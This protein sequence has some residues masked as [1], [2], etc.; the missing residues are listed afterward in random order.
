MNL[1]EHR[2]KS[3]KEME[4]SYLTSQSIKEFRPGPLLNNAPTVSLPM[5]VYAILL[6]LAAVVLVLAC[7]NYTNLSVARAITRAKEIG[8]RKVTGAKRKDLI[9][10]FL[11]ESVITSL[12]ALLLA[13]FLLIF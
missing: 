1:S 6:V 10:Q 2:F 11:S 3:L 4:I 13:T 8:V 7:L 12:F 9:F 5:P